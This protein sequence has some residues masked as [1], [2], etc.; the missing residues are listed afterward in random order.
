MLARPGMVFHEQPSSD[1]VA[2]DRALRPD[3][4]DAFV[5]QQ[6]IRENLAIAI[7]AARQRGEALD[8][9]L[10]SGPPGLGKTTLAF[11][12]AD[13]M[14]TQ[15]TVTSGPALQTGRELAPTL[16]RLEAGDVLFI[17][18]IHRLPRAVEEYLYSAMEDGALDLVL[19]PGPAGRSVRIALQPFTL[20]GATTREGLL[21]AAFR[22]R[23]GIIERLEPYPVE[24][25]QTI[26]ERASVK[27]GVEIEQ[28]AARA[29]AERS[30]G[31]PRLAL[32][33]L[34]R[35]RDLAQ[36]DAAPIRETTVREGLRRLRIDELG[37]EEM[38]RRILRVLVDRAEP[39]GLKTLAAIVD[40]AEDT[41]A[42][43]F[44]PH[45]MRL[46]LIARTPRG[47]VATPR[48]YRHLGLP[49]PDVRDAEGGQLPF[50]A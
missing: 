20:V 37:L 31:V 10:F 36:L 11:L 30:R 4:L 44:E 9:V 50:D 46:G 19:D 38:D 2:F 14:G 15:I 41:I 12:I 22:S 27:L 7:E 18:E 16:T 21:A 35:V 49:E 1:E 3:H 39:V 28:P 23:F 6:A 33:V 43:V 13:A 42:D 5:G 24:D 8:H 32:R 17:D 26:L 47:R 48:A 40:E 25:I 45:L 29:L 34:R